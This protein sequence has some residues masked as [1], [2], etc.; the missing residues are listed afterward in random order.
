MN[1]TKITPVEVKAPP[2][3]SPMVKTSL[4]IQNVAPADLSGYTYFMWER[5]F[6]MV[7]SPKK[8]KIGEDMRVSTGSTRIG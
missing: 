3:I 4:M 7:K 5:I 1:N 2:K 8:F 6:C